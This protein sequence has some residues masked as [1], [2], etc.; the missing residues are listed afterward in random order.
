MTT[1]SGGWRL[2]TSAD[3]AGRKSLRIYLKYG[4]LGESVITAVKRE[5]KPGRRIYMSVQEMEPV[6]NGLGIKVLSTSRGVISDREARTRRI[7]G[8]VLC[9]LW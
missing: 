1:T 6:L 2:S 8:E 7:G 4:P 9:E 5:S 3:P